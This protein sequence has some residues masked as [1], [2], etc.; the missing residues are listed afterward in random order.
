VGAF[1]TVQDRPARVVGAPGGRTLSSP[2]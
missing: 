2:A 1:A